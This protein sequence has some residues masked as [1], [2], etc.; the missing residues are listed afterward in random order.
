MIGLSY[1]SP[2]VIVTD[3]HRRSGMNEKDYQEFLENGKRTHALG[4]VGTSEEVAKSIFF[5]ASDL[6]SFTTGQLLFTDGGRN[7]MHPR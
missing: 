6:S 4:R 5:L 1:F 3:I 2:G 7:L